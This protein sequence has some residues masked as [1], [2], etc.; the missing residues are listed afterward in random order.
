MATRYRTLAADG[1]DS[2]TESNFAGPRTV[3]ATNKTSILFIGFGEVGQRFARDWSSRDDMTLSAYDT[4]FG[5]PGR[6][7]AIAAAAKSLSVTTLPARS[8]GSVEADIVISA[9]TADQTEIVAM[10]AAKWLRPEQIFL[11]VNSASPST[12]QRAAQS[13]KE[14]HAHYVEGAVMAAVLAPGLRVPILAGG[15]AAAA[16]SSRLNALGMNLTPVSTEYGRASAIK[17]CRSIMIKGM[18]V[19]MKDCATACDKW[20][21]EADVYASLTQTF[22]SIN[23][24]AL[25]ID[26]SERVATHG[27]RR[28]AE[29]REAAAM[30]ADIGLNPSLVE[31]VAAA[32][33]RGASPKSKTSG[34]T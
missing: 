17:L 22:P 5:Q 32:Q 18:E 11:D 26:M 33:S 13:V 19:L 16:V 29:M 1:N 27:V 14:S 30:L 20:D 8:L 15:P 23:W 4:A 7:Q 2:A 34:Q 9:V 6:G 31:A 21:V 3:P 25:A 10:E 12:K 28:A 24:A